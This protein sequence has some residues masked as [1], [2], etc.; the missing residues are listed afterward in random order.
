V[1]LGYRLAYEP[2][3]KAV[4]YDTNS[5]WGF[6]RKGLAYGAG[7]AELTRR[8]AAH[9]AK[10]KFAPSTIWRASIDRSL[11]AACYGLG[12]RS[13]AVRLALGLDEG[14]DVI[15]QRPVASGRR[16][17]FG[18]SGNDRVRLSPNAVY[19]LRDDGTAESVVVHVAS[20][21]RL[22]LDGAGDRI[23]RSLASRQGRDATT[24][25]LS[26]YYGIS[27]VTAAADLDDFVDELIAGGFI[28]RTRQ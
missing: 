13:K 25:A 9:G 15:P 14:P 16:P 4:H 10:N 27:P 28:E 3:A 17:W 8:Y 1:L 23:W 12:Y 6:I 21:T 26:A 11:S 19:W 18:W 7:A 2:A 5:W 22:V 20:R 24:A